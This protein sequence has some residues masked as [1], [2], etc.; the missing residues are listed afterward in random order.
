VEI[1]T[2][3]CKIWKE[4]ENIVLMDTIASHVENLQLIVVLLTK[5]IEIASKYMLQ[6]FNDAAHGRKYRGV[7]NVF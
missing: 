4:R 3:E 6:E 2:S 7:E 5:L 1:L